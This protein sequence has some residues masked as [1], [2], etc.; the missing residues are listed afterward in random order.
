VDYRERLH[1]R[2]V[3]QKFSCVHA[4]NNLALGGNALV[5]VLSGLELHHVATDFYEAQC[6]TRRVL[7]SIEWLTRPMQARL[8]HLQRPLVLKPFAIL[9]NGGAVAQFVSNEMPS[10]MFTLHGS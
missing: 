7:Q 9:G 6:F 3:A 2:E 10:Q 5:R 1:T 4:G 8:A